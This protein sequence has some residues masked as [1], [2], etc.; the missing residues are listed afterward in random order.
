MQSY[1]ISLSLG[2]LLTFQVINFSSKTTIVQQPDSQTKEETARQ[3]QE[4]QERAFKPVRDLLLRE[5]VPFDPD[6]LKDAEWRRKLAPKLY[7]MWEMH[8]SRHL[9][10]QLKGLQLADILYLPEKVDLTDDTVIIANKVIFEGRNAVIKGS[11]NIAVYPVEDVGLLGMTLDEALVEQGFTKQDAQFVP[12]GY[13]GTRAGK[14]FIP[15]L[16]EDGGITIDTSGE[17]YK[18]WLEKQKQR[19]NVA[20]TGFIKASLKL[21][22]GGEDKRGSAGAQGIDGTLGAAGSA[23]LPNPALT[24]DSGDCAS[25]QQDGFSGNWG[26]DGGAGGTGNPGGTGN[27]GGVGGAI[28]YPVTTYR[29]TYTFI[30]SGGEGGKGG[31]GGQGGFGGTGAQGGKGGHGADCSCPP[32]NGGPGGMGGH[33]GRG[34]DGGQGGTGGTGG[35]GGSIAITKPSN[36]VGTII[37]YKNGGAAGIGGG[38]GTYG[39]PGASGAGGAGGDGG[40]NFSCTTS[41]GSSGVAG[42]TQTDLGGGGPGTNGSNGSSGSDGSFTISNTECVNPHPPC[43]QGYSWNTEFCKCCQDDGGN[44]SSPI[45]VDVSGNGFDLTNVA[46]G[47][48]FDLANS[49][50][51]KHLAWTAATSDDAWLALDRNGNGTIDNGTELFGNFTSQ[52]SVPAGQSK[53]GF[54]ALAEFDRSE[55]GGNNDGQISSQDSIFSSLKLWQ[56]TNHNGISEPNELHTLTELG[57]KSI[58]LDYK[59]SKRMDQYGNEFGYR[60]KVKDTHDAQLGR[61]AWDVFLRSGY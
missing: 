11:H 20:P 18:E 26:Q 7:G 34:G 38:A 51:P 53:N 4:A 31:T 3:Q 28:I 45:L 55:N 56:D 52:P 57:L 16:I 2:L 61:W 25:G 42:T 23:G 14:R 29:G 1:C 46:N 8:A 32:G 49:G 58:D 48:F 35:Q 54:L 19:R 30:A 24:G 40:T 21:Q 41:H 6:L 17:G 60:A 22:T 10:K 13:K 33:G 27:A 9:G 37:Y 5:H 39:F 12:V 15:Y 44:C 59:Q 36:F 47:V 50:T 43:S